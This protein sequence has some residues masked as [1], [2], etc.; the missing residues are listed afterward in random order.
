MKFTH[1]HVHSHYSLLDGLAKIDD[2]VARAKALGME[3]LALTDHGTLYGA[4]EFFQKAKKAG[5]KPIVGCEIYLTNNK[6]SEKRP[7]DKRFHLTLL[8]KNKTGYGNLVQLIT[9]AHLEGFYYKPRV[10]KDCLKEHAEGLICLSGCSN[11]EISHLIYSNQPE[12]AKNAAL[13]YRDIF[14]KENFYIELQ[15][16]FELDRSK[17]SYPN[18]LELAREVEAPIVATND[19]HYLAKEDDDYQDVLLAIGT[20]NKVS[21]QNRLTMKG[22]N[23]SLRSAQE[24]EELFKDLPEAIENTQK[25][26][27]ACNF[28][29]EFGTMQLPHFELPEGK[30][31]EGYLKEL[32]HEGLKKLFGYTLE[33]APEAIRERFLFELSVIKRTG[34]PSY[35][36]IVQDFVNW[37]K[38]R[39]IVV[40]PGR[41]SAAGSLISYLIGITNIDP[42]KYNLLFER[43]LNPDRIAPPD[44]DLDFA[45]HRRDEVIEYVAQKYGRDH[46]AQIITFGTMASRA[47]L[48]DAGRA[49]GFSY[50]F[51]DRVAK[52]IPFAVGMT[53]AKA[54]EISD[55]LKQVMD[56]DPQARQLIQTAQKL[57]GVARH[58]S[59]HAC[60]VVIPQNPITHY[61][62]IQWAAQSNARAKGQGQ[63]L[64]TQ[65]DMKAVEALGL[66]KMD[67]LG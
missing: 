37:A 18:L 47:A 11:S 7:D 44:I 28:E 41:G 57:E 14:G 4:V 2:L 40:G 24:M 10:D 22:V 30:T 3:S 56:T 46:V 67:F 51:C 5:L 23:L 1:L 12:A 60:G 61:M 35:I 52:M 53:F 21:D 15:P 63:A 42:I 9:K 55:E 48:R 58:A 66:L 33:E 65:Y 54:L 32:A 64:V 50:T 17:K 6:M 31:I 43:F 59:T 13:E 62:P 16:H 36:L 49:L 20:G 38:E 29:F 26:A 27:D 45:D 25:I 34:F 39:G 19:A 8:I